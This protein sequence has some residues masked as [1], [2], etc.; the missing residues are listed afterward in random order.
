MDFLPKDIAQYVELF[1]D[2]ESAL[3]QQINRETHTQVLN[4]RML[5]GH[6]QGRLLAF[7]SQMIRPS[8][9]L[10]VGTYTGYS[11]LCLAEGLR[12]DGRLVT[13]E[14]NEELAARIRRYF[15]ASEWASQL[16]LKIGAGLAIIPTLFE[17]I[18]LAFIDADKANYLAYYE[19]I[20]PKIQTGGYLIADNVLWS[21]KV[22]EALT[23]RKLDKDTRALHAFNQH[24]LEDPRVEAL[25]LP[26][27][28]GLMICRKK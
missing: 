6:L 9:V 26:I 16:E 18:D 3:L 23:N 28:D 20:L 13:I 10:E 2:K 1:T 5:S 11:A 21:G 15:A 4:P 25:L 22:T 27:R 7:F 24:C 8:Y 14:A 12:P 19:A 17:G